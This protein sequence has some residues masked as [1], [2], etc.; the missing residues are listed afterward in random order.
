[1]DTKKQEIDI[2]K[3]DLEKER[4]KMAEN[5]G[6]LPYAHHAGS[7]VVRS[8]DLGKIKGRAVTAMYQQ[9]DIQI[10]QIYE[11]MRLLAQQAKAIKDRVE[12]SERIYLAD[13]PFEP[14]INHV[15]YLYTREDGSDVLSLIAPHEWTGKS[16]KY[17]TYVAKLKLLADHTWEVL[18]RC[19]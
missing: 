11:Q 4:I 14:I 3:I 1:M 10:E 2:T 19:S 16:R 13:I 12:L 18:E 6:T 5:P 7:A 9:T 17:K 15:Y 8:E